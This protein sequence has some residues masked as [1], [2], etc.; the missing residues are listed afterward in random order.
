MRL[1]CPCVVD[2]GA[3]EGHLNFGPT[4]LCG[5]VGS[6]KNVLWKVGYGMAIPIPDMGVKES[7]INVGESLL[8]QP[9]VEYDRFET[10]DWK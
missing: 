7:S 9:R 2:E 1:Y 10:G 5:G 6:K 3:N 8:P 4:G